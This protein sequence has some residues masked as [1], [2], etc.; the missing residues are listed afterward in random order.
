MKGKGTKELEHLKFLS[1]KR[2]E[3]TSKSVTITEKK[4]NNML[5]K[6]RTLIRGIHPQK[7]PLLLTLQ[8]NQSFNVRFR[9]KKILLFLD[10]C[11]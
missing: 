11:K 2:Q 6:S 1:L 9:F 10:D 4:E 5:D 8:I 3:A 7:L